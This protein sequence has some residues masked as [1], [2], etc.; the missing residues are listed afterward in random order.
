MGPLPASF[1]L[2]DTHTPMGPVAR[3]RTAQV[4]SLGLGMFQRGGVMEEN[5]VPQEKRAGGPGAVRD[6]VLMS[7]GGK[8]HENANLFIYYA[9]DITSV[10][11]IIK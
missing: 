11:L 4:A 6:R 2:Q 8:N 5:Q 3:I 10:R 1:C 9:Y 7:Q